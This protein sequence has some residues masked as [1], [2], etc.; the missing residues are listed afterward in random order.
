ML[1]RANGSVDVRGLSDAKSVLALAK[2]LVPTLR[3]KPPIQTT[4][5]T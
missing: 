4:I 1:R 2:P 3:S 5:Q